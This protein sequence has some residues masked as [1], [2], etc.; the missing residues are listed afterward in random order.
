MSD[1]NLYQSRQELLFSLLYLSAFS[2]I[3]FL[4]QKKS[5]AKPSKVM[6]LNDHSEYND[7]TR[8][9]FIICHCDLLMNVL[10][11]HVPLH[12]SFPRFRLV[13]AFFEF[14]HSTV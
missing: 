7:E 9:Y 6:N 8:A 11:A 5:N 1:T 3:P 10:L 14:Q 2:F 4:F 12:H 13:F